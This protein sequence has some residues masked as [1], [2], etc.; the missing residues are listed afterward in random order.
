MDSHG[1]LAILTDKESPKSLGDVL[2][3][4]I[5]SMAAFAEKYQEAIDAAQ[6]MQ[7]CQ[8]QIALTK[9]EMEE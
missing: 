5:T 8:Y 9:G 6:E 7:R 2:R 1:I 3:A 4:A